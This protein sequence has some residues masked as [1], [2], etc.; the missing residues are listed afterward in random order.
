MVLEHE[1]GFVDDPDDKGKF[2]RI[3]AEIYHPKN[4]DKSINQQLVDEDHAQEYFG[5]KR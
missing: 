3:L 2:G 4:L 5:G 1:G